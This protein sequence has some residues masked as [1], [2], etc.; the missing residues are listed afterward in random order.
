MIEVPV[1]ATVSARSMPPTFTA[2]AMKATIL[3]ASLLHIAPASAGYLVQEAHIV[4]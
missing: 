4:D 1:L 3:P 2:R